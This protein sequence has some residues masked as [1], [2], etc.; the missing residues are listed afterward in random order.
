MKGKR[1]PNGYPDPIREAWV[2]RFGLSRRPDSSDADH[3]MP[4]TLCAQLSY[5]KSDE[6][7]RLILGV[8]K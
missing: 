2:L 5:C 6:A 4:D 3:G 8:S 1:G 7:R